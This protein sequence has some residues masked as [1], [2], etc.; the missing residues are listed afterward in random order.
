MQ[1]AGPCDVVFRERPTSAPGCAHGCQSK[2]ALRRICQVR[3][4]LKAT[5]ARDPSCVTFS[6]PEKR[7]TGWRARADHN[8]PKPTSYQTPR[9]CF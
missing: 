2:H 4:V 1:S 6:Y 7:R 9:A 3:R 5:T 8:Y